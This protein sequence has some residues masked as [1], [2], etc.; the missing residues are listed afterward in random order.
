MAMDRANIEPQYLL[1]SFLEFS[2]LN[3]V[4]R[5]SDWTPI[6]EFFA[7]TNHLLTQKTI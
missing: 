1:V 4:N 7:Y 2:E 5:I 6:G 3:V